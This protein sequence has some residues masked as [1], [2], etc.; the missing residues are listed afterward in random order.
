MASIVILGAG[1]GGTPAAFDLRDTLDKEHKITLISATETFQFSQSNPWLALGWRKREDAS[2]NLRPY[3]ERM[4]IGFIASPAEQIDAENSRIHLANGEI[5]GYDYLIIATGPR[6]AFDLIEGSGPNGG[7]SDSICTFDHACKAYNHYERFLTDPGQ[8]VVGEFQGASCFCA[9]YE[10]ILAL[11]ADLQRRKLRTH[12]PITYVT[13]EPYIGHLGMGGVGNS[14]E[15]LEAELRKRNIS[16]ICNAKTTKVEDGKMYVEEYNELGE[17]IHNH[18]LEFKYS[19][20]MPPFRGVAA[21]A[22][23]KGLCNPRGLVIVDQYQRSPEF[24]N[25]FSAGACVSSQPVEQTSVPIGM[26]MTG[27]MIES[28]FTAI[29][30]NIKNELEGRPLVATS[31]WNTICLADFGDEGVAFVAL[32][33]TSPCN[34]A[35]SKKGKWVHL[36]KIAFEKYFMRKIKTGSAEP[37]YEKYMLKLI[38]INGINK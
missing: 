8:V 10:Y 21:V 9:V 32:S 25:I 35:W 6:M 17:K 1:S 13:P 27:Y 18:E 38:G 20:M 14:R 37:I 3:L 34:L 16:W 12:V 7:Y 33:Q 24:P 2:F 11:E 30:H 26:P 4:G 29:V 36:A 31:T 15:L 22:N 28:M 19:M 5:I 23:V